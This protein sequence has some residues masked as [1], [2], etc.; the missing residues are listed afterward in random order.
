MS[1]LISR[2]NSNCKLTVGACTALFILTTA[3]C[4]GPKSYQ[5]YQAQ[6]RGAPQGEQDLGLVVHGATEAEVTTF[7]ANHPEAKFRVVDPTH[8]TVELFQISASVIRKELPHQVRSNKWISTVKLPEF[9]MLGTMTTASTSTNLRKCVKSAQTPFAEISIESPAKLQE[10]VFN[11]NDAFVV[12]TNVGTEIVLKGEASPND[13]FDSELTTTFLTQFSEE[14]ELENRV[15]DGVEFA[16]TPD[17]PGI[18]QVGFVAQDDRD[19]CFMSMMVILASQN[20]SFEAEGMNFDSLNNRLPLKEFFQVA[21]LGAEKAWEVSK[22]E[23]IKIAVVDSGVNYNHP[24][25]AQNIMTNDKEIPDN[26]RDDD[27]NGL[28]DDYAGYDFYNGDS[29]PYDDVG[30]GSHVSGLAASRSFG[31]AKLAKIL[32]VKAIGI[33]GGDTASIAA[34]IKYAV[35]QG[36]NIINMSFGNY[37][38]DDPEIQDAMDYA[39]K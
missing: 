33:L 21:S 12:Q 38:M 24:V 8:N 18:Y 1:K 11:M 25:L 15:E 10:K 3:A 9:K 31:V 6:K 29:S 22:G 30:H 37:G 5:A 26:G 32:P 7:L 39:E 20:K 34:G 19:A 36:A 27:G 17:A 35:D 28:V 14:S 13:E 23:G 16:F 2:L 4:S